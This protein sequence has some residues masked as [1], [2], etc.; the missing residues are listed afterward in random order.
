MREIRSAAD[1]GRTHEG[2]H[3]LQAG[4]GNVPGQALARRSEHADS[5]LIVVDDSADRLEEHE[6]HIAPL[7]SLERAAVR[8]RQRAVHD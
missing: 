7:Q 4:C 3:H 6:V 1:R 8:A 5:T 2:R